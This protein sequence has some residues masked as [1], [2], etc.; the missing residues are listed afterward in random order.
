MQKEKQRRFFKGVP[1]WLLGGLCGL[2]AVGIP[3][4]APANPPAAAA[5]NESSSTSTRQAPAGDLEGELNRLIHQY[6]EEGRSYLPLTTALA[7]AMKN[8]FDVRIDALEVPIGEAVVTERESVFDPE[9]FASGTARELETQSLTALTGKDKDKEK[10][11]T[12][13][14]GLE[15]KFKTGTEAALSFETSRYKSNSGI[16][17][18]DPAYSSALVLDLRQPLLRDWGVGV[19]T[20]DIQVAEDDLEIRRY[21][22]TDRA[23]KVIEEVKRIYYRL[24]ASQERLRLLEKSQRLAERLLEGNRKRL[25]AGL[26]HI[27]EVQEAETAVVDRQVQVVQARRELE[28]RRDELKNVLGLTRAS[29]LRA[30]VFQARRLPPAPARVPLYEEAMK[31]ALTKRPDFLLARVNV[32]KSDVL[33][34]FYDNQRLYRLDLIGS[35]GVNG[36]SGDSR[37]VSFGDRTATNPHAGSYADSLSSLSEAEGYEWMFGLELRIPLGNREAKSRYAQTKLQKK[38]VILGLKSLENDIDLEVKD[39]LK[40]LGNS[41]ERLGLAGRFVSLAEKTLNQEEERMK[42][43]LSDTFRVL[44]FQ[45]DLTRAWLI[46]VDALTESHLAMAAC[47]KATGTALESNRISLQVPEI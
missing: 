4:L 22:F 32:E 7:L 41:L 2:I 43:G 42:R 3:L 24:A 20:T 17:S 35:L 30:V 1:K 11:Q 9:F 12:G 27:G 31:K 21:R 45:E 18:L 37:T 39:A 8:N 14:L 38:Q 34:R 10:E 44:D 36:L 40:D 47:E 29:P 33:L 6:R 25:Q 19:N 23:L 5:G 16:I 46:R 26:T 13:T 28:R 15:K